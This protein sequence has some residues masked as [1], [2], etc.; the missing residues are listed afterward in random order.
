M[1]GSQRSVGSD[2]RRD[3]GGEMPDQRAHFVKIRASD[4]AEQR[5]GASGKAAALQIRMCNMRGPRR[6]EGTLENAAPTCCAAIVSTLTRLRRFCVRVAEELVDLVGSRL[7]IPTAQLADQNYPSAGAALTAIIGASAVAIV[8]AVSVLSAAQR[9]GSMLVGQEPRIHPEQR[10]K[11]P[12]AVPSALDRAAGHAAPA[13][14][15]TF[16]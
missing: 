2:D 16:A 12:P 5:A 13:F 10:E 7:V 3:D 9:A 8:K 6:G 11:I 1:R 4:I 14:A 15:R